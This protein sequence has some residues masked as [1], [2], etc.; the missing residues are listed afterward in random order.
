MSSATQASVDAAHG[1]DPHASLKVERHVWVISGVV[2]L[3]MI[4]SILDTTIVNVAL[5]TLGHEL[6]SNIAQVQWVVTGYLLS[7]GAVIPVTGWASRRWGARRVYLVSLVLFTAGS[8][9]CGL[10]SS[11]TSLV[12]FRVLQGVGGGMIMPVAQLIMA[13]VA[14]PQRM[15]RV[16]GVVSMPA[17]L[18]PIF[19]P[20]VGG[21]ILE[22][23]HWSWIFF[24]NVPVGAVAFALAWRM[25]PQTDSGEAGPLDVL[26][27]ALLP[28]GA[29]AIVY[30]LSKLGSGATLGSTT[31]LV[32]LIAGVVLSIAFTLHALRVGRAGGRALLDVR[33]YANRVFSGASFTTFGLGAALFGAM[34]LVPLYYQEVRGESV[35]NTGLLNAPQG[36]GALV[37]MPIAGRLTDRFGGG[38]IALV[39]VSLLCV[40]TVPLAFV[41]AHSSIVGLSALLVVR[42]VSIGLSFMPAMT[43]AFASMRP[44][45]LSDATPQ[46]NVLMRLGSAIG[47]AILAVVLQRA[48]GGASVHPAHA[49]D[50]AYWWGLGIAVASLI[51]CLVL[52][53]AERPRATKPA[54]E[55]EHEPTQ[56]ERAAVEVAGV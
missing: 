41:G 5:R 1:H 15:G 45:Q 4:M 8:A 24:V 18:A 9:A 32:P 31:V 13:Q 50:T 22:H 43:A 53:R 29:A 30:G 27:L 20:V 56:A 40:S 7:L 55:E 28:T 6:H 23:L 14:G 47:V 38:R 39:G 10:S 11:L 54:V 16:M 25:L 35:I 52:L 19:G 37:A 17:M 42:G 51:P 48:S 26:G 36:I 46:I 3:G 49:F 44:D 34:V 21:A 2:I 33:L 12:V